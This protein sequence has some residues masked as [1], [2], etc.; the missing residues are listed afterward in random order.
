M[1][2]L[3]YWRRLNGGLLQD[4]TL[5]AALIEL[6]SQ[7]KRYGAL[8]TKEGR[9]LQIGGIID[10]LDEIASLTYGSAVKLGKTDERADALEF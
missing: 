5:D 4:D 7:M 8:E 6:D 2:L 9:E 10:Q 3:D 1:D